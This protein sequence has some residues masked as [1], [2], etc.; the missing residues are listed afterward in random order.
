MS[1][2]G[3]VVLGAGECGARAAFA[4]REEGY[5]GLITLIGSELHLPYERPPLSK[6]TLVDAPGHRFVATKERYDEAGIDLRLGRTA[7]SIDSGVHTVTL[8]DG[9]V[10]TYDKLLLATGSSPRR[11]PGLDP[12]EPNVRYLRTYDDAVQI[13]ERLGAHRSIAIIGA[14][15]IGLELAATARK[16]GTR[17]TVIEALPRVLM[18]GVP[19]E[20]ALVIAERHVSEGVDLRCGTSISSVVPHQSGVTITLGNGEVVNA[21]TAVVGIG[22]VPNTGL[23]QAAGLVIEN[24]IAVDSILQ[25]SLA[26]I[27]AA[28]DCCSFPLSIYGNRRVRLEAWRNAQEQGSLAAKSMIGSDEPQV[29]LPYF[30]SDQYDLTLQVAGLAE[31]AAVKVRREIDSES[32]VIFHLAEDG[33]LIAAS[34]VGR[35]NTIARD[36]KISERLIA[37]RKKP[38]IDALASPGNGLKSLLAA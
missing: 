33:T 7:L 38:N 11:L 21:G 36:I 20:I 12:S 16:L 1:G 25:T 13:R 27:Y 17:V 18:R 24:G 26:D 29:S 30:W 23:A 10:L 32:F 4:L 22:S 37:A 2:G 6:S 31:G 28:G 9:E 14:G 35:G 19:E 34:G 3:M 8:D 5:S 15:F